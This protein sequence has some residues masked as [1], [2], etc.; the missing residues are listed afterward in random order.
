VR[1][2]RP[3]FNRY[4]GASIL[5]NVSQLVELVHTT[6]STEDL[7]TWTGALYTS[8][9]NPRLRTYLCADCGGELVLGQ[10]GASNTVEALKALGC[11]ACGG[12][13]FRR[14]PAASSRETF[15]G[16]GAPTG[17]RSLGPTGDD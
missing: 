12:R 5:G 8:Q 1:A 6:A 16:R 17:T 14:V 4:I 15:A 13:T 3:D 11:P 10:N 7:P 9:V 2:V